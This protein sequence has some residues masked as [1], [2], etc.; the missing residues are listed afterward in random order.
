[1]ETVIECKETD[2]NPEIIEIRKCP[3]YGNISEEEV[4]QIALDLNELSIIL[5]NAFE[6]LPK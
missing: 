4:E 6:R 1:M 2:L 5:F 3:G